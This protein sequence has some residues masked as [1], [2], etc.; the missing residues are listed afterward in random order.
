MRR[1]R[2][3]KSIRARA[4][5]ASSDAVRRLMQA[6]RSRDTPGERRLRSALFAA[7]LR[8]RKHARPESDLRCEAD[9][10]FRSRRVCVFVDGCYWHGC[11]AHFV[12]PKTN[13][14][15]WVEKVED[16]RARDARRTREL[17]ERGWIVLRYW[18]HE[19]KDA[20][21]VAR[22]ASEVASRVRDRA[23]DARTTRGRRLFR[24][25]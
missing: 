20:A 17:R 16:N 4:P 6:V 21:D 8:F 9:I 7:G 14:A 10:V 3:R 2:A 23:Q 1:P 24:R 22:I 15:W 13:R 12:P 5:A 11:P 25:R 18:G 19:T